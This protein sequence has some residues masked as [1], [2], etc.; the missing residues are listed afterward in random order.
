MDKLELFKSLGFNE[1]ESKALISFCKLKTANIKE[2][3][4]E[5]LVPKNKLYQITKKLL[6]LG[7]LSTLPSTN[8]Y[9][10]INL[11]SFINHKLEDKEKNIKEIK[12]I[13]KNINMEDKE[14]QF[15]F[16]LIKGQRAIM[17]KLAEKNPKVEKEILGVQRNWKYWAEGIRAMEKAIKKGVVV[18][19]IGVINEETKKRADEWK[20]IGVKIK[21]YNKKFGE[22]PLRFSIFDNKEARIT[23][24][25]P[26]IQN[27]EDYITIWTNSKPLIATLRKQFDE[28]WHSSETF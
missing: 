12:K 19:Q 5:S 8:K 25:K 27:P 15:V 7:L 10:L 13:S 3:S 9:N 16:S 6:S 20:K 17:N 2:I 21:V 23:I 1:Y 26:E 24:G 22:H 14:E 11:Q 4:E 28:M 18:K